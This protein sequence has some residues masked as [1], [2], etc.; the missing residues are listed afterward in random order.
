M[1]KK[2]FPVLE[3]MRKEIDHCDRS[4]LRLIAKRMTIVRRIAAYKRRYS[5][6]IMQPERIDEVIRTRVIWAK[7]I[8]LPSRLVRTIFNKIIAYAV[9]QESS[10]EDE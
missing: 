6:P 7:V 1:S 9:E 8:G 10:I 4:L 5:I 3:K 2:D